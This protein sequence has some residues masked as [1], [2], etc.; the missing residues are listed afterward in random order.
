[1]T[2]RKIFTA[3]TATLVLS[4]GAVFSSNAALIAQEFTF[5]DGSSLEIG[6]LTENGFPGLFD[7]T[8]FEFFDDAFEFLNLSIVDTTISIAG[9]SVTVGGDFEFTGDDFGFEVLAFNAFTAPSPV[10][11]API[12]LGELNGYDGIFVQFSASVFGLDALGLDTVSIEI[13]RL[14]NDGL[15]FLQG[16]LFSFD[17]VFAEIGY[18]SSNVQVSAPATAA[19][20]LL[21]LMGLSCRRKV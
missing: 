17:Q 14:F 3:A 6:A 15:A 12:R 18:T 20:V 8:A 16:D 5:E 11:G 21:S 7:D 13:D 19:L 10:S 1:M 2:I 9:N 4:F